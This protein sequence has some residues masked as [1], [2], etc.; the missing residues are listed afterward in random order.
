MGR[1][2]KIIFLIT[3]AGI[4]LAAGSAQAMGSTG[5]RLDLFVPFTGSGGAI[6]SQTYH[7]DYTLGQAATGVSSGTTCA[8]QM[9]YWAG[10]EDV[11]YLFLPSVLRNP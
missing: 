8:A 9:G 2:Q 3:L 5:Y 7:A 4:I 1:R 6:Q 10:G 11:H